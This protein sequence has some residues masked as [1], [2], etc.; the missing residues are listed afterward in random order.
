MIAG[1]PFLLPTGFAPSVEM[2]EGE[3]IVV[4]TPLPVCDPCWKQLDGGA[5]Q[6]ILSVVSQFIFIAAVVTFGYMVFVWMRGGGIS[7]VW[8][9]CIFA[10]GI[11]PYFLAERIRSRWSD[12]LKEYMR[13]VPQYKSLLQEFPDL[14]VL[15]RR[16]TAL[17]NTPSRHGTQQNDGQQDAGP[18]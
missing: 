1:I 14:E 6:T 3:D 4:G 11:P 12:R 17:M 2:I 16:P 9:L 7:L 18:E 10:C 13:A 8:P 15:T 5:L